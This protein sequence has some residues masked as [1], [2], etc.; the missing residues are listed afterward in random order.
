MYIEKKEKQL[1]DVVVE[2]YYLCDK[3]N[4]NTSTVGFDAFSFELQYRT[5]DSFHECG[6]GEKSEVHLCPSCAK[7]CI[8][9][10][11]SNGFR[12]NRSNWAY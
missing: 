1:K 3:C 7:E 6:R 2:S 9:L 5:G 11:E 4:E 12:I 8:D 10:L